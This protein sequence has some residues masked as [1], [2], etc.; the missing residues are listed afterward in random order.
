MSV[1]K[2]LVARGVEYLD[3]G[4]PDFETWARNMRR[5]FGPLKEQ[6]LREVRHWSLLLAQQRAGARRGRTN[7]WE[8]TS[9]GREIHGR[10]SHEHGI[11]P[12]A[13]ES[14]LD[15]IHGGKNGGRACWVVDGTLCGASARPSRQEKQALCSRCRFYEMVRDTEGADQLIR[16]EVVL[17]LLQ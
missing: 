11:C 14:R 9:C 8:F 4:G 15:G 17:V 1:L 3:A 5:D 6:D 16:D 2:E 12:A 13:L 10:H 7:C